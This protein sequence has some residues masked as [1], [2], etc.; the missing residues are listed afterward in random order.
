M[1]IKT[2]TLTFNCQ[3]D[4][5]KDG[6]PVVFSNSL[7]SNVEM[8][9]PQCEALSGE[10]R[11][12]RYDTRGHGKPE[13]SAPYAFPQLVEDVIALLD[14]LDV[15]DEE[16][17]VAI[18]GDK[19]AAVLKTLTETHAANLAMGKVYSHRKTQFAAL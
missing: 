5:P 12:I 16:M 10:Y 14:V 13:V 7:A 15:D 17:Y 8:W 18:P 1:K 19:W 6:I 11:V 3:I 2:R 4:G 9:H